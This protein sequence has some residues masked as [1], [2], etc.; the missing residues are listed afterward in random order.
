MPYIRRSGDRLLLNADEEALLKLLHLW[1]HKASQAGHQIK[2]IVVAYEAGTRRLSAGALVT[3]R[4]V[5]TYA[6]GQHSPLLSTG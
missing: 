1:R 2:R 3:A 6:L 4:D 5:A